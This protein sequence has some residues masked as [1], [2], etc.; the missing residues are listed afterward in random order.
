MTHRSRAKRLART[1]PGARGLIE[2]QEL[3]QRII[4][5]Q[6][7]A[8]RQQADE[9][10][11][12]RQNLTEHEDRMTSWAKEIRT[13][14]GEETN[15]E[16][17][18]PVHPEDIKAAD[19]RSPREQPSYER[20]DPPFTINW[21]VPPMGPVSGGHADIFRAIHHL[22]AQ[23]HTCRVYFYDALGEYHLEEVR[24]ALK[25]YAPIDA[26][27]FHNA[28]QMADADAIFATNWYSA[29]PAYNFSGA[30]KRFYFVQDFEPMFEPMGSYSTLAENTYRFGLHGV[31][32]GAWL[33]EKLST[34]YGMKCDRLDMGTEVDT[35][36][37]EN[38]GERKKIVFYSRPV[39]PRRGFELGSLALSI[40]H[41][42][43]PE[44]EIHC[45]GWDLSRYLLPFPFVNRGI[46][47]P[48]ELNELYNECAAGLVLSFTNMSLLPLELMASGCIPVLNDAAH[49]RMVPYSG[50]ME[51]A[52]P[53]PRA[54]A[55]ALHDV[56]TDPA[57]D[58]SAKAS[59]YAQRF[60]WDE[61]FSALD[62]ILAR[63][64]A[65]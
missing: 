11:T 42:R 18:W 26:E 22:E 59:E 43:H 45:V 39:T 53:N 33:T 28:P 23:G 6:R 49:T 58:R 21:V 25:S 9:I 47:P 16:I 4:D 35:Y 30:A 20:H 5:E 55:D 65:P 2:Q 19:W 54:L 52:E 15:L 60:R 10:T 38:S 8:L 40:F 61:V 12:L 3:H 64:L 1:L 37:H 14:R 50:H 27:L 51:Y 17:V 31:T 7:Q 56:V 13:L 29:Y 63:E 62:E 34:E 46:L 48:E 32:L 41:E 44:Y 36:R 24:E 57:P